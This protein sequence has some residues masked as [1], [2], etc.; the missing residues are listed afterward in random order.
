MLCTIRRNM[1]SAEKCHQCR[2]VKQVQNTAVKWLRTTLNFLMVVQNNSMHNT[3]NIHVFKTSAQGSLVGIPMV[4]ASVEPHNRTIFWQPL[5]NAI[6][7]YH[8]ITG[9]YEPQ[10]ALLPNT[11]FKTEETIVYKCYKVLNISWQKY[12]RNQNYVISVRN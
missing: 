4:L 8:N 11:V 12:L 3:N 5:P 9:I 1:K 10:L 7:V 2:L 6:N